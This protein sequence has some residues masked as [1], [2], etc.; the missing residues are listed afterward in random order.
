MESSA[1]YGLAKMLGHDAIAICLIIANRLNKEANKNYRE[2][3]KELITYVL[4]KI[5]ADES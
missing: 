2:K 5:I 3:V 1:L 4:H